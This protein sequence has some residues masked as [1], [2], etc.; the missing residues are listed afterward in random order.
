MHELN[1]AVQRT[2]D[3]IIFLRIA[4]D[5]GIERY[6]QLQ[7]LTEGKDT[8]K[9]LA[10]LFRRADDRY[11]S[12]LFH[13]NKS[14]GT[15]ETLDNFTL[16]LVVD[17]GVLKPIIRHLYYPKSP[18]EFAVMPA[19]I[20][21]QV[22]EQFLGK[23]IRLVG[24]KAVVEEKPEVKKAG[25]VYYTPTFVVRY[26]VQNTIGSFL[27]DKTLAQVAGEDTRIHDVPPNR[28]LAC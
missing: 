6:G 1:T 14:D 20:L 8:Y 17:D 2:I 18:Y 4:E 9:Q 27:K 26:I 13:F 24:K 22:Y 25:G 28:D 12:G 10:L 21:G 11:N 5:R 16:A 15:T 23:V 7:S 19:D 3:R